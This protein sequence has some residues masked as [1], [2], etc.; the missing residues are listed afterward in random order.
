LTET[1][2]NITQVC[3]ES[4]VKKSPLT[5]LLTWL[6]SPSDDLGE[7]VLH[8]G[9]W[10]TLLNVSDRA[11][12][13]LRLLILARLLAPSDFGLLGI[14]LLTMGVLNQLASLGINPALVQ[15]EEANIDP[16]LDTVWIMK[17]VRGG[18]L[19]AL[20]FLG[21]PFVASFFGEP[22][23][24]PVLQVLG[25]TVLLSGLVN[26]A[27]V[28]FQKDL[29]FHKQFV[30]KMS[31]RMVD[32]VVAVGAA[33]V[34]QNVWALVYGLL[35]GR[36]T[37][38]VVS[39]L[40]EGYRPSLGFN[41]D[42]ASEVLGFGKWIW[43]T[44]LVVF[45]ATAGDDAFVG[46]YLT[47]AS[48]GFYQM[49]FRL[50]NAPATEV[51]H[52]IS[53]VV[54]PAYSKLQNDQEALRN[55]FEKT[56]RVTF[57]IA[58]PLAVGI[59]LVAPAFTSVVLGE[60]WLPMVPAM[61]VMAVAGCLRAI[62]ATGGALF[63]GAG[64]PDWDFRM[65][66]LRAGTIVLTI[67]PLTKMWGITGAAVSITIG[68]ATTLPIWLYKTAEITD[69]PITS[70]GKILLIPTVAAVIMSIPVSYIVQAS[71]LG[72]VGSITTGVLAYLGVIS[73]VYRYQ[74]DNP[75]SDVLGL[76]GT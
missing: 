24:E 2:C 71:V 66:V 53:G 19:F 20:L 40:L 30:Y 49:A 13:I 11:L 6:R 75:I 73:F 14:A 63:K 48:L 54:F 41:R 74:D 28:Y 26:P 4:F 42:A 5:R 29:K 52:V 65:N 21:A 59:F 18:G 55:A 70:Y 43:A 15:R 9:L 34:L 64:I 1:E 33:L 47:A 58:V 45:I 68:I 69:I 35:A 57:V 7:R 51:T 16:Y 60:R 76:I 56:I 10:V 32:F 38:V 25:V 31:S 12:G 39:Y 62:A 72:L 50:S 44:G 17:I 36:V 37:R 61:Q 46:W 27:V 23:V 22:R 3:L 8:G 67:W